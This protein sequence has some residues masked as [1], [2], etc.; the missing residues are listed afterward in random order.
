M[1]A[2]TLSLGRGKVDLH[3]FR[4]GTLL[5]PRRGRN[6]LA[7]GKLR[8]ASR[9]S[10]ALGIKD[11]RGSPERSPQRC[12]IRI[13]HVP[14]LP[15]FRS[16]RATMHG[17]PHPGRRCACP[18]LICFGPFGASSDVKK[19][20]NHDS[21]RKPLSTPTVPQPTLGLKRDWCSLR[22][23]AGTMPSPPRRMSLAEA[24]RNARAP[25]KGRSPSSG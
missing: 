6:I 12:A 22:L 14:K 7:Q 9:A 3:Q 2:R 23:L 11:D 4:F 5:L 25:D 15:L 8:G 1:D 19:T 18:G 16:F 17:F 24:R 20:V 13:N 21:N 10:A